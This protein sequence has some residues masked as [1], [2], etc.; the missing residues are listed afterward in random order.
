[1]SDYMHFIPG[2]LRVKSPRLKRNDSAAHELKTA[3]ST[4]QGID[5][6]DFNPVTGSLLI[7]YNR[8]TTSHEDIISLFERRG[9]F[10]RGKTISKDGSLQKIAEKTGRVIGTAVLSMAIEKA[11]KYSARSLI[12]LLI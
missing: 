10:D 2:R 1:M 12:V 4:I 9:Y 6:I 11:F 7:N 3:L 5:A 8:Q